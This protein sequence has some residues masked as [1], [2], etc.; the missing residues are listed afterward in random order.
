MDRNNNSPLRPLAQM[1]R[2]DETKEERRLWNDF[3]R[4]FP[5]KFSRRKE[6]GP[7]TIDF[8]CAKAKLVIELD[9]TGREGDVRERGAYLSGQGLR[10]LRYAVSDLARDF[11]GVCED[12]LRYF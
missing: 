4:T 2:R 12:I 3:L 9:G 6:I 11:D 1:L 10:V 7:Y 5:V 8:Y